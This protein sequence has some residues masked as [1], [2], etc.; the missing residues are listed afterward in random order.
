MPGKTAIIAVFFNTVAMALTCNHSDA[1]NV[2]LSLD[3]DRFIVPF[4]MRPA[5]R[6]LQIVV[7]G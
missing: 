5:S 3:G 7:H 1:D 6:I 4:G 2:L